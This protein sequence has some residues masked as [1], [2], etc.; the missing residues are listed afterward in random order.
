MWLIIE[1]VNL[2]LE[3]LKKIMQNLQVK[4]FRTLLIKLGSLIW[5]IC[6]ERN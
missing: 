6:H 2:E 3:N 1:N 5:K 4:L